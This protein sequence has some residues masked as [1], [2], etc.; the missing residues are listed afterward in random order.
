MVPFQR[1]IDAL[2]AVQR[3]SF[4]FLAKV[5]KK[6]KLMLFYVTELHRGHVSTSTYLRIF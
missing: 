5:C 2:T 4:G 6:D 3:N 1:K